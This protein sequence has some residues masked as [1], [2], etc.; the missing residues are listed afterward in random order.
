M[1]LVSSTFFIMN[2]SSNAP[3][4]CYNK[5]KMNNCYLFIYKLKPN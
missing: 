5:K 2:V 1:R 4:Q 3:R